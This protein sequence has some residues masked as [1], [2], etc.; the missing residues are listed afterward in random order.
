LKSPIEITQ[1]PDIYLREND[2]NGKRIY[3]NDKLELNYKDGDES[4]NEE[5]IAT[6]FGCGE[7][8]TDIIE[9]IG[10][11]HNIKPKE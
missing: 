9:V 6:F 2:R 11:T 4:Y 8:N 5:Y 1:E 10:N 3:E 7:V